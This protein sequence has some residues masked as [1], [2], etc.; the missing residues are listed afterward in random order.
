M[1]VIGPLQDAKTIM[2]RL[3]EAVVYMHDNGEEGL[4]Y[5]IE[6]IKDL[7]D[8]PT[9]MVHRDLKLENVLL[10]TEDPEDRQFDIKVSKREKGGGNGE[11]QGEKG[12]GG[13]VRV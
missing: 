7:I 1:S 6:Q 8:V 5:L 12:K 10:S 2:R 11:R 13:P 3:T 4:T 9:D